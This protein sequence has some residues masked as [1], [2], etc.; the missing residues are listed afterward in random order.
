MIKLNFSDCKIEE[1][2]GFLKYVCYE[3]QDEGY[4]A[5][6]NKC[7]YSDESYTQDRNFTRN[8]ASNICSNDPH[9]YQACDKRLRGKITNNEVLCGHYICLHESG[10]LLTSIFLSHTHK[11]CTTDCINTVVNK[12]GCSDDMIALPTG[13]LADVKEICNDVCDTNN[14]E[15]EANCNGYVYGKYCINIRH[16]SKSL[17]YVPPYHQC[18]GIK[19]CEDGEDEEDCSVTSATES[20]CT[21]KRTGE[22]V[23]VNNYQWCTPPPTPIF[24]PRRRRRKKR[25]A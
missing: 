13:E 6:G 8:Y 18:D 23:P 7:S 15:D 12:K 20:Y 17:Y 21:H 10:Y 25:T 5:V 4:I 16:T 1:N 14:C 19:F 22:I 2:N 9:F 24:L 3:E 11:K